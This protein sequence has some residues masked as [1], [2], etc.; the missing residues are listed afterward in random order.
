M[1]PQDNKHKPR[2]RP[3]KWWQTLRKDNIKCN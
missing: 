2:Q 3:S 1:E